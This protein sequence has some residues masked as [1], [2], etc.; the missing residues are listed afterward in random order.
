MKTR[1]KVIVP[2]T[3]ANCGPGFDVLG[4]ACNLYNEF[5]YELTE[6]GFELEV[7][8]GKLPARAASVCMPAAKIWRFRR[9]SVCGTK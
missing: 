1:V 8:G 3:S 5:T 9:S 4:A 2:A 7:T 6:R